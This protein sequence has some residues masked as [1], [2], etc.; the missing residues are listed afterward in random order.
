MK[1]KDAVELFVTHYDHPGTIKVD[2][3]DYF[4]MNDLAS[5]YP[6]KRI[7]NWLRLDSTLD[8]ISLVEQD[9]ITSH[10]SELKKAIIAKRGKYG[11]TY[12]HKLV[13][14]EFCMWLSPEFKLEVIK[15]VEDAN[16]EQLEQIGY[17]ERKNAFKK[18]KRN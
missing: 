3:N 9:L 13:T 16:E 8:F 17:L 7:N 12:A 6:N 4:C 11:G 10:V 2:A 1:L 14:M 15:A 18:E 5:F